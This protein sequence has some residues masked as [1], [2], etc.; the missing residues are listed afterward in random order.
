[1]TKAVFP[2]DEIDFSNDLES[3]I[4]RLEMSRTMQ[5]IGE[6]TNTG[7]LLSFPNIPQNFS[8]LRVMAIGQSMR[9]GFA[10][11]GFRATFNGLSGAAYSFDYWG[12][13]SAPAV[14]SGHVGGDTR[15]YVGQTP[16]ATRT[17]DN[18][19]STHIIDI[20]FYTL[21]NVI[22]MFHANASFNDGNA[23]MTG[24][25]IN[26]IWTGAAAAITRFDLSD[27]V[28]SA[29]GPRARATLYGIL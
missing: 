4:K 12:Y 22:H 18:Y 10:N 16:A 17:N 21:A 5:K 11:T 9:A 8:H 6:F 23:L 29:L 28:G 26:N 20:P 25:N 1:M 15:L 3:R 27:D 2:E 13:N 24:V 19:V 14:Y 7:T